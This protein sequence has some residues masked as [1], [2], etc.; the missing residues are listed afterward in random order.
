MKKVL[1]PLFLFT[2]VFTQD[3]ISSD[4]S[5]EITIYKDGFATLKEP[6]I[7]DL[8]AG[9]IQQDLKIFLQILF[10]TLQILI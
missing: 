7:W 4:N 8:K 3:M 1:I 2:I 10:L 6:I 5:R 9:K